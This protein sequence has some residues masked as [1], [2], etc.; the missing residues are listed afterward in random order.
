MTAGTATSG[1]ERSVTDGV[2]RLVLDRP[3]SLNAVTTELLEDLAATV[4]AAGRDPG[5]RAVSL[6]G[7]GRAFSS[8][9]DLGGSEEEVSVQAA[10]RAVRA[11]RD[12]PVPV[13][14]LVHGPAAGVGCSLA[15][16]CDLVVMS[17]SAYLMLAFTRIGLM[18]D[19]GATALVAASAGRGRAMRMALLAEKMPAEEA[20]ACGLA[21]L[22]VDDDRL[23]ADGAELAARLA[24]G[25]PA[26]LARTKAAINAASLGELE[27]ALEREASGQAELAATADF[28]EGVAA[29][30]GRRP[31]VF[32][33]R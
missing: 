30:L 12:V 15:L 10:N 9:A 3:Q 19:G 26:A 32:T 1:L 22:V 13:L 20:L 16:A 4:T 18:P 31:P 27:P 29:F 33:G 6:T 7:A 14:A 5:I 28:A 24:A 2:L 8:G 17:R 23:Q 21:A 25:P 11:I